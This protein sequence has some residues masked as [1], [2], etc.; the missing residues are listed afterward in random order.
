MKALA[1]HLNAV[2]TKANLPYRFTVERY[3]VTD[4]PCI[5]LLQ[6]NHHYTILTVVLD[7]HPV[8]APDEIVVKTWSENERCS[9]ALL[10]MNPPLFEDTGKRYPTGFVQAQV[11]RI[12][13]YSADQA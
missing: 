10:A 7:P 11:W 3:Y 12:L 2:A 1:E 8:C 9:K 4:M 13:N 6:N 5:R